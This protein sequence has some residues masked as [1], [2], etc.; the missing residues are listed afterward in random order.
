MGTHGM[1]AAEDRTPGHFAP[2]SKPAGVPPIKWMRDT[3]PPQRIPNITGTYEDAMVP[4]TCD[5]EYRA[6]LF[7]DEFLNSITVPE[8]M[9]E[10]FNRAGGLQP[11]QF[12]SNPPRLGLDTGSYTCGIPKYREVLPLLRMM[13]GSKKGL[14]IDHAWAESLLKC[15]GPDGLYYVPRVGRPWDVV[16]QY[17]YWPKGEHVEFFAPLPLCNGRLLGSLAVNWAA[18]HDPVWDRTARGVVDA[19]NKNA[20]TV[21]N[22]AF[23]PNF[24]IVW[25][26]PPPSRE[27]IQRAITEA[28]HPTTT[29]ELDR[30]IAMW[31]GWILMG[32]AQYYRASG[33]EPAKDLAYRLVNYQRRTKYVE[34]W[35]CHFHCISYTI[36][37]ALELATAAHDEELAEYARRAYD[38]SKTGE[39]MIAL[40]QIGFFVNA[41]GNAGMEGCVIGDMTAI[42]AKL[43]QLGMGD[44]YWEDLDRYVRN[45][46]TAIQRTHPG[47][48][49]A[50]FSKLWEKGKLQSAPLEYYQL[51]DHLPQRLVG[52]FGCHTAPNDIFASTYFDS[53]CNGNCSRAMYYAWESILKYDRNRQALKVNLMLNRTSPWA[54]VTSYIPYSGRV[55]I[56]AKQPLALLEIRA[57]KWVDKP[58]VTCRVGGETR[59]ITW[60]GYYLDAGSVKPGETVT[61]E[62]PIQERR[63]KLQSFDHRYEAVFKGNDCV[64]L[65]P[66]GEYY[67]LY[68]RDQYRQDQPRFVKVRRFACENAIDF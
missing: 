39:R 64:E 42:A 22:W 19:L 33:Y 5:L 66:G 56:K 24:N 27:Q 25:G 37:G 55:E 65:T 13:T 12:D 30:N 4:D 60:N 6:R 11:A 48:A 63:E 43:A 59:R 38:F 8:L 14:E 51:A 57:A 34:Q 17:D 10:P 31:Q 62:F 15:I 20:V 68:Q 49:E 44:Q 52:S 67:S 32:L 3:V 16:G 53:C 18:T 29:G 35:E 26:A 61:L 36:L 45:G 21:E 2:F 1:A 9:H 28:D 54:D 50:V 41:Q 47:Y 46:L 40:P 58:Q 7:A 23:F